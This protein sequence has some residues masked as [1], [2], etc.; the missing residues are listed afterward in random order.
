MTR[1]PRVRSL[2]M[3]SRRFSRAPMKMSSNYRNPSYFRFW[4]EKFNTRYFQCIAQEIKLRKYL[5]F[6]ATRRLIHDFRQPAW[7]GQKFLSRRT[8]IFLLSTHFF[9]LFSRFLPTR[10]TIFIATHVSSFL[11]CFSWQ[12]KISPICK[13]LAA[14]I[15]VISRYFEKFGTD[16][17]IWF[18]TRT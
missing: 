2:E 18:S 4:M 10:A 16:Q 7:N 3:A 14:L 8:R 1:T 5:D 15:P 13:L 6:T 9:F 17:P 12:Y 11:F